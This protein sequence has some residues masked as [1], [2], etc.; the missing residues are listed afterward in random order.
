[1]VNFKTGRKFQEYFSRSSEE[2]SF[3]KEEDSSTKRGV[4]S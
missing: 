4:K 3:G 2:G 1:M